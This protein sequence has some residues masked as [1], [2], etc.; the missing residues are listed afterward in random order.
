[1]SGAGW[2]ILIAAVAALALWH[3]RRQ[4]RR[5]VGTAGPGLFVIRPIQPGSNIF[6]NIVVLLVVV[7]LGWFFWYVMGTRCHGAC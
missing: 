3:D 1:M 7:G 4:K 2:V 6:K 5:S